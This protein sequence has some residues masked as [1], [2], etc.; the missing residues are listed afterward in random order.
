MLH[1][2]VC[3]SLSLAQRVCAHIGPL[4]LALLGLGGLD[5]QKLR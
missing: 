5:Y 1:P 3:P 4:Q 2:F